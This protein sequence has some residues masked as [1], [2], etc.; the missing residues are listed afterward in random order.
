MFYKKFIF[1]KPFTFEG[2][3]LPQN[4]EI[5]VVND[6]IYVNGGQITPG[7]YSL[8]ESLIEDYISGVDK[9]LLQ[10]TIIPYNKI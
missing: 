9:T 10:E 6:K 5:S 4:T 8:F 1:K 7:Y 2:Q 3:T